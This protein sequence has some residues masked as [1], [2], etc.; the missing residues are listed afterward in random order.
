MK[1]YYLSPKRNFIAAKD[2]P[3]IILKKFSKNQ[4]NSMKEIVNDILTE[5]INETLQN[6]SESSIQQIE[7]KPKNV[8][9]NVDQIQKFDEEI[10]TADE[11]Y[12]NF[13]L[14]VDSIKV[15][16]INTLCD[17]NVYKI[18][19]NELQKKTGTWK[20]FKKI[21]C[22]FFYNKKIKNS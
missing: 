20:R 14:N 3:E 16:N 11:Y 10:T 7:K 5:I 18:I 4:D 19:P 21:F 2:N 12:C 8:Q 13:D 17:K 22:C 9:F 15:D 1:K 6:I